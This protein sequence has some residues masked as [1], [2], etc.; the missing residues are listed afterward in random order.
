MDNNYLFIDGSSLLSDIKRL[1]S[2]RNEFK[3][4]KLNPIIFCRRFLNCWSLKPFIGGG[5]RR[6]VFYFVKNDNRVKENIVIPD[7]S[8]S[9]S[10]E[11][12]QFKY[13]GKKYQ[14]MQKQKIG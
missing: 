1:K 13:C 7:F 9:S 8:K 4:K 3:D 11:D 12:L 2:K 14:I 6:I 10:I 5:Y